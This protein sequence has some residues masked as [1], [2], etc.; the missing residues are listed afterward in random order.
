MYYVS[1]QKRR[2]KGMSKRVEKHEK[3]GMKGGVK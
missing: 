1:G 2:E 3:K